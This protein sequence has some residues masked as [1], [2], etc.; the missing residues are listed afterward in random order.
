MRPPK[1]ATRARKPSPPPPPAWKTL[2]EFEQATAA[3]PGS[4][5]ESIL[6]TIRTDI[7]AGYLDRRAVIKR[8]VDMYQDELSPAELRKAARPIYD[9]EAARH[10]KAQARW[11][12]TTD[13]DRLDAAF[14][15][16]ERRGILA[17][18]NYWC[19]GT[20]G[21]AA[22][23][24]EMRKMLRRGKRVR[25]YVFFHEQDTECAVGG[26]RMY[27]NYGSTDGDDETGV[28][29]GREIVKVL[30]SHRLRVVW[31][32]S[33]ERRIEVRL[34]WRRR[35]PPPGTGKATS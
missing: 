35:R 24:D 13:C 31:N 34:T 32:G 15:D 8:V 22:I 1:Q 12:K 30:R 29:I 9:H 3:A 10:A 6:H 26:N 18:Q 4:V 5:M 2:A 11:P 17:R 16:L 25:G 28:A 21:C 23:D 20:C 27:L 14:A 33:I 19:C 7:A